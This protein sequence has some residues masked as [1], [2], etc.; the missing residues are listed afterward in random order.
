MI[1]TYR[2]SIEPDALGVTLVHEHIFVRDHELER[3]LTGLE[4]DEDEAI[5]RAVRGL[6]RL[7]EQGVR[8]V[9]DLTVPGLGRDVRLVLAVAERVPVNL[10]AATGLYS[11]DTLPL[12]FRARGPDRLVGGPEPLAEMFLRDIEAGIAGTGVRAGMVKV[13]SGD[14]GMTEGVRQVMTAAALAHSRT[15]VP[16]T[17]HSEPGLRNGLD[18]QAWLLDLGVPADRIVIGHAGDSGDVAYLVRLM[19]RG[20]LV[21][22]DRFG[23]AHAGSDHE[24]IETLVTLIGAGYADRIVLSHDA[25]F[26]SHVTPPSWRAEHAPDWHMEHLCQSILPTLRA[27]GVAP[28]IIDQMLVQNPRR[29]LTPVHVP[30][31]S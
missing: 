2:G 11:P 30:V 21:G 19:D 4:W 12:H 3:N 23:M 13:M 10:I 17:T 20:S 1:S 8:T 16:I 24:R 26:Y 27:R 22:F 6:T 15:G 9:V 5:G 29:L 31:A 14:A 28:E 18:Q 7:H 25:A